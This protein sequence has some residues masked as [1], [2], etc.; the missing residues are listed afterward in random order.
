M[1]SP[2]DEDAGTAHVA[3]QPAVAFSGR[4]PDWVEEIGAAAN[5]ATRWFRC[6]LGRPGRAD[7]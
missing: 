1:T 7:D 2:I 3:C 4:V 6:A 5:A